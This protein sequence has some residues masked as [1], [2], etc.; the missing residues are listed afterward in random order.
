MRRFVSRPAAALGLAL[1]LAAP[2]ARAEDPPYAVGDTIAPLA[3]EDQHGEPGGV[4]AGPRGLLLSRD[5]DAGGVV[6]EALASDGAAL[7]DAAG[8]VYVADVHRMPGP[9]RRLFA[10]PRMRGRPYRVLLDT[11]GAPTARFPSEAGRAAW[12]RLEGLRIAEIRFL[13]TPEEVRQALGPP[14]PPG[15]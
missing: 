10:I 11:D 6:R 8:A 3:L 13:A 5:M 9:I 12:L 1:S 4:D 14:V 2:G 7:L 15:E